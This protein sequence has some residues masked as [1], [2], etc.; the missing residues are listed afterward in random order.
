MVI[1]DWTWG[2]ESLD[3]RG[4]VSYARA[5]GFL[6]EDGGAKQSLVI[7]RERVFLTS[8]SVGTLRR[9]LPVC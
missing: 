6:T 3:N 2:K 4:L 5:H 1:L 7:A 8:V 9:R